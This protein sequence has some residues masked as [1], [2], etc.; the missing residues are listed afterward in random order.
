MERIQRVAAMHLRGQVPD[1]ELREVLTPHFTLGCK[2]LLLS[3]TYYPSLQEPNATVVPHAVERITATGVVGAAGVERGVD[4]IIF[5]TGFHVP[6]PPIASRV[7]S[8][9]GRTM[10]DAW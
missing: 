4:P 1:P 3:N 2:R 8:A 7:R 10:A 5:G 6:A 9:D